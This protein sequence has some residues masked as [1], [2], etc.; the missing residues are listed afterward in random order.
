MCFG[1]IPRPFSS[2]LP[3]LY[4]LSS[5]NI[6]FV[7]NFLIWSGNSVAFFF[8]FCW[9]LSNMEMKS[10]QSYLEFRKMRINVNMHK[11]LLIG[12]GN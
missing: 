7:L 3:R 8:G 2:V 10:N 6:C 5:L 4:H 1:K 11:I 12:V 9:S